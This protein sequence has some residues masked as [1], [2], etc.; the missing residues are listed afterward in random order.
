MAERGEKRVTGALFFGAC[1]AA[2]LGCAYALW[3]AGFFGTAFS[4]MDTAMLLRAAA[5][6]VLALVGLEFL[7]ALAIVTQSDH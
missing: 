7:A 5:A 1:A 6:L 2:L 4:G 3:P